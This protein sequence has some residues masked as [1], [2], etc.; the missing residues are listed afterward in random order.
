M[1][2]FCAKK[3]DYTIQ[4]RR[5]QRDC[6]ARRKR[7]QAITLDISIKDKISV[8]RRELRGKKV[9]VSF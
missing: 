8:A 4:T 1:I 9:A 6:E 5:L 3:S 2:C 7:V